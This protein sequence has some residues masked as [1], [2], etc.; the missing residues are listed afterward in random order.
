[1]EAID[2]VSLLS[3]PD[4]VDGA[5][6]F[7][8]LE[9][10]DF[11]KLLITQLRHQDPLEPVGNDELLRQLASIREIE[12]STTISDSLRTLTGQQRFASASSLIGRYVT[13]TPDANGVAQRGMVVSVR[14]AAD[15]RAVLQ[16][17]DGT[18]LG[19]DQI[20]TIEPPLRAAEALVGLAVVGVDRRDPA[21]TEVVEAVVT[22]VRADSQGEVMLELDTGQDLRFRDVLSVT[23]ANAN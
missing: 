4:P 9:G 11:L 21:K 15:G 16:L 19:V 3:R 2:T 7:A 20:V 1:M 17:A 18:E 22:G 14:F 6:S 10:E 23:S 13:G 8:A 12:L 5:N